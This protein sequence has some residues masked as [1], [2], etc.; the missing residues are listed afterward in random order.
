M[1]L[2]SQEFNNRTEVSSSV[3]YLVAAI[4]SI[5]ALITNLFCIAFILAK[6]QLR[7][8]TNAILCSSCASVL[9]MVLLIFFNTA[10][11]ISIEKNEIRE[12][13]NCI[14]G[15][16]CELT[17]VGIFNIHTC[18]ISL[19]RLYSIVYPFKYQRLATCYNIMILLILCW[20]IPICSILVPFIVNISVHGSKCSGWYDLEGVS[21]H[22][23]FILLP[24]VVFLPL[25]ITFLSYSV[26]IQRICSLQHKTCLETTANYELCYLSPYKLILLHRKA[27]LQMV[28][29]ISIYMIAFIPFYV[30]YTLMVV[31]LQPDLVLP[32]YVATQFC[33][34]Y[35]IFHPVLAIAFRSA[36]KVEFLKM[37][38]NIYCQW[39]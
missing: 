3:T 34:T 7:T 12:I 26:I 23:D 17:C 37:C 6:S 32:T 14:S 8:P 28:L 9:L 5:A 4:I 22:I 38:K 18:L 24:I 36:I 10:A 27:I 39:K 2:S 33:I 1:N 21:H 25:V 35:M 31:S 19:E 15:Q 30:L 11:S 16:P 29:I 20:I 13:I